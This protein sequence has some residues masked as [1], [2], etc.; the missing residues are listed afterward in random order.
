MQRLEEQLYQLCPGLHSYVKA[1]KQQIRIKL[2]SQ[3]QKSL[4][5]VKLEKYQVHTLLM[6]IEKNLRKCKEFGIIGTASKLDGT[7]ENRVQTM[8]I[9][10]PQL[11]DSS[12]EDE[13]YE[14]KH[15]SS[16]L[17]NP[18]LISD[19][20]SASDFEN[21]LPLAL[22]RTR[23]KRKH[24][25]LRRYLTSPFQPHKR[26]RKSEQS[27]NEDINLNDAS[28]NVEVSRSC[29]K[30][31]PVTFT[32]SL[33]SILRESERKLEISIDLGKI[34]LARK[35]FDEKLKRRSVSELANHD[36]EASSSGCRTLSNFEETK[37]DKITEQTLSAA[38]N[39]DALSC[40]ISEVF[41]EPTGLETSQ[42]TN[43]LENINN[44]V[45]SN[46]NETI[47]SETIKAQ[48]MPMRKLNDNDTNLLSLKYYTPSEYFD[49]GN[50][51]AILPKYTKKKRGRKP[52]PKSKS[53]PCKNSKK[54]DLAKYVELFSNSCDLPSTPASVPVPPDPIVDFVPTQNFEQYKPI[55]GQPAQI[56]YLVNG[57][58]TNGGFCQIISSENVA[59]LETNNINHEDFA[60]STHFDDFVDYLD[61]SNNDVGNNGFARVL[62]GNNF[63]PVNNGSNMLDINIIPTGQVTSSDPSD[64][65]QFSR[66]R[67]VGAVGHQLIDRQVTRM[68]NGV[69]ATDAHALLIPTLKPNA[70][71]HQDGVLDLSKRTQTFERVEI[72][73]SPSDGCTPIDLSIKGKI[74]E[75]VRSNYANNSH[76]SLHDDDDAH[77]Q[78]DDILQHLME[79]S[80]FDYKIETNHPSGGSDSILEGILSENESY[81]AA[82]DM[83]L[84][85]DDE[86]LVVKQSNL[87]VENRTDKD[88]STHNCRSDVEF[89][90]E[91]EATISNES[92]TL[93]FA[94]SQFNTSASIGIDSNT[95]F[96][97]QNTD[98]RDQS[99]CNDE[100][101][102]NSTDPGAP[103]IMSL[104]LQ[105]D[106]LINDILNK[107]IEEDN[108]EKK[109]DNDCGNP[110]LSVDSIQIEEDPHT[111]SDKDAIG[112]L[113]DGIEHLRREDDETE[114]RHKYLTSIISL[115]S[116]S[117]A[118]L[119][120]GN[121]NVG[122]LA[123]DENIE[124]HLTTENGDLG[125]SENISNNEDVRTDN[126]LSDG[127][128]QEIQN[129]TTVAELGEIDYGPAKSTVP[130]D[131][132]CD[133]VSAVQKNIIDERETNSALKFMESMEESDFV[134]NVN[135][136]EGVDKPKTYISG[137]VAV[138]IISQSNSNEESEFI[139]KINSKEREHAQIEDLNESLDCTHKLKE[140]IGIINNFIGVEDTDSKSCELNF[141]PKETEY[142]NLDCDKN[143]DN[144]NITNQFEYEGIKFE[145]NSPT[146]KCQKLKVISVVCID[147][148]TPKNDDCNEKCIRNEMKIAAK[149]EVFKENLINNKGAEIVASEPSPEHDEKQDDNSQEKRVRCD[150][151]EDIDECTEKK[152]KFEHF[153]MS[154]DDE[155]ISTL[156]LD[157]NSQNAEPIGSSK[158]SNTDNDSINKLNKDN[159]RVC[160]EDDE[161]S[162]ASCT[163]TQ[164]L[165]STIEPPKTTTMTKIHELYS[166]TDQ[167]EKES[168]P[169]NVFDI[170]SKKIMINSIQNHANHEIGNISY[171]EELKIS[172][173]NMRVTEITEKGCKGNEEA[174]VNHTD[175]YINYME[176]VI[177]NK[178]NEIVINSS[179][180]T[181]NDLE[182][183]CTIITE[184]ENN[185]SAC[186]MEGLNTIRKD[187]SL[188]DL[189]ILELEN[190]YNH[191]CLDFDYQMEDDV[192]SLAT[193]CFNSPEDDRYSLSKLNDEK[194]DSD[195]QESGT[196]A[197]LSTAVEPLEKTSQSD[198]KCP[199][200]CERITTDNQSM[201]TKFK[202]PKLAA[203]TTA[204]PVQQQNN[205]SPSK[206]KID[207]N[208]ITRTVQNVCAVPPLT[209]QPPII[210]F[211]ATS[212]KAFQSRNDLLSS[213]AISNEIACDIN[214]K[215]NETSLRSSN[216]ILNRGQLA[217]RGGEAINSSI[218][219]Y[220]IVKIF[221]PNCL[222]FLVDE[223]L[224]LSSSQHNHQLRDPTLVQIALVGLHMAELNIVYKFM[225]NHSKLF[226]RYFFVFCNIFAQRKSRTKLLNM[227]Y[228]CE[229]QSGCAFLLR[230]IFYGLHAC[231]LSKINACRQ[232]LS[233]SKNKS[234]AT[235]DILV[236]IIF[237]SDWTIFCDHLERFAEVPHYSFHI[238]LLNDMAGRV[239]RMKD[240]HL[241]SVV[242]K[243]LLTLNQ[244]DYKLVQREPDLIALL[245]LMK[246]GKVC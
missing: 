35:V 244:E 226:Q 21:D 243:C 187:T 153:I 198:K 197:V 125:K 165:N 108:N 113:N 178:G 122:A 129:I 141:S 195:I 31:S 116:N 46:Y 118:T 191:S 188:S 238:N 158:V 212:S 115:D 241:S 32:I 181:G 172:S 211:S 155:E 205:V 177:K 30:D 55:S 10:T 185:V 170:D 60:M 149:T 199:E 90:M 74:D 237:E 163:V 17:K 69:F 42:A 239:L 174:T 70:Y 240:T 228:D 27:S 26:S 75:K 137:N 93:T 54:S 5:K 123:V 43:T 131:E 231:G 1:Q 124:E 215:G 73:K 217:G 99:Y 236:G 97:S 119:E 11:S 9:K 95:V 23:R 196:E 63:A 52:K 213:T 2:C 214:S 3:L 79:N 138:K 48:N 102:I 83:P 235:I 183:T 28:D 103:P 13:D 242:C 171:A 15:S 128:V 88:R 76:Q 192:L 151:G 173:D 142:N 22:R 98:L 64:I 194:V 114:T 94:P 159:Q 190:T 33:P 47:Y 14:I 53:N 245:E 156:H 6:N 111:I 40:L 234:S 106:D 135:A 66:E 210:Q 84:L 223:C 44:K 133:K 136:N 36:F 224:V 145:N 29:S 175:N 225:F 16:A 160:L 7:L 233:R 207:L 41:M 150:E 112:S 25:C 180:D 109:D 144:V 24:K 58:W 12:N 179:P 92:A 71:C 140:N 164:E 4:P 89:L 87:S 120:G 117:F 80:G 38:D 39:D 121:S 8:I 182:E 34:D 201:L 204:N 51:T 200:E 162:I 96:D 176:N 229:K 147:S 72:L 157:I 134:G 184:K 154:A 189:S 68:Q 227:V 221:G 161:S 20:P 222:P 127:C 143:G 19:G 82:L 37:M 81:K 169:V 100:C 59:S 62:D 110:R 67:I 220:D 86:L 218:A 132:E 77:D 186:D 216:Y 203:T 148:F 152:I 101:N 104:I 61:N 219:V 78:S 105:S 45:E 208:K 57:E 107:S 91:N 202:I 65:V 168:E 139:C 246:D 18:L 209:L 166:T 206:K 50:N 56:T 146:K 232:I 130:Q 193:S 85:D 167:R 49:K 230:N 126:I